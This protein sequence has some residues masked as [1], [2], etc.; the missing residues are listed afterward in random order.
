MRFGQ[1]SARALQVTVCAM[2]MISGLV[3][4][5]PA[6]AADHRIADATTVSE[7]VSATDY[8]PD[9]HGEILRLYR[10]IFNREPDVEGA[11]YWIDTI[12][13]GQNK[14]I[15]EVTGFIA[16]DDQ[17][18]FK[19]LYSDIRTNE[20]FIERIYSNMLGRPAEAEGKEYWVGQMRSGLSRGNTVRFVA[21]SEEFISRFPYM[22]GECCRAPAPSAPDPAN[23]PGCP[24]PTPDPQQPPT[25]PPEDFRCRLSSRHHHDLPPTEPPDGPGA[26]RC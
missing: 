15:L 11:K 2:L 9:E 6:S 25:V 22:P 24:C 14:S 16:T 20:D 4:A 26:S 17:P 12:Y 21:L 7:I 8:K 1:I 18:E 10:A 5:G 19:T 3:V 23:G 13:E